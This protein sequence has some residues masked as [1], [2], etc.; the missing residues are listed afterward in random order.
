MAVAL[1]SEYG[2]DGV[3][4]GRRH[5]RG[6]VGHHRPVMMRRPVERQPER[7]DGG[8]V[9]PDQQLDVGPAVG[10]HLRG[11]RHHFAVAIA[12]RL[13]IISTAIDG[14]D[15]DGRGHPPACVRN[16]VTDV[17]LLYYYNNIVDVAIYILR[18]V[19]YIIFVPSDGERV[20]PYAAKVDETRTDGTRADE[21]TILKRKRFV[22]R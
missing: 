18:T 19:L 3:M 17:S 14:D 4:L 1:E 8:L 5:G 16:D 21:K 7:G 13:H 12:V 10:R 9:P 2:I 11:G 22:C 6:R 20:W 15:N